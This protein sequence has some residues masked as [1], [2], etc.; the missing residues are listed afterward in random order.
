LEELEQQVKDSEASV[1]EERSRL[2]ALEGT[3]KLREE[4]LVEQRDELV[5]SRVFCLKLVFH[6][7]I[8][9]P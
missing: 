2:E 4:S 1:A 3:L 5:I 9:K 7:V 6:G 8:V